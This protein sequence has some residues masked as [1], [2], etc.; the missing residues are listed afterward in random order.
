MKN[1]LFGITWASAES[2]LYLMPLL[3]FLLGV[4]VWQYYK[5][6]VAVTLL[7]APQWRSLLL[8]NF[9]KTKQF[10][11]IIFLAFG[12]GA[13][14]LAFMQ[15]QWDRK[16][17]PICQEGRDLFIALDISRSM[18]AQDVAPDR[19]TLAK[20]K[21][22]TLLNLLGCERLGLMLFSGSPVVQCPL[23]TDYDA[24]LMFLDQI[25]YSTMSAGTTA[26]DKAI[27]KTLDIFNAVPQK[28]NKL[29]VIFT[30]GEDFSSNLT[31]IK[32]EAQ[33]VGLRIVTIGIG[34]QEGAPIP[35]FDANAQ[36]VGYQ[37][38]EKGT[39]VISCLNEGI[40]NSLASNLGGLY[41][42]ASDQ[43][44]N[45]LKKL[46]AYVEQMEKEKFEDKKIQSLQEQY[47]YFVAVSLICFIL[48]WFL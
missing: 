1:T 44:N 6:F 27:Q 19:L 22:K 35:L 41:I 16:E 15:P 14:L 18:L 24:F 39:A 47:H 30:D 4:I 36:K 33:R 23:T 2:I 40:L 8:C 9:S 29:L 7:A 5:R 48:E 43:N 28:K 38:D 42:H 20:T 32:N 21:I 45:D 12:F 11:K 37:L 34:T 3:I 25:D 13:L 26:L 46:V 31:A 17:E 10:L